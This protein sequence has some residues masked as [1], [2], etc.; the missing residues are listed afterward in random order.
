M[1]FCYNIDM[2]KEKLET[3]LHN[4]E[5]QNSPA[6]PPTRRSYA[7]VFVGGILAVLVIMSLLFLLSAQEKADNIPAHIGENVL[8][9]LRVDKNFSPYANK[10]YVEVSDGF[11]RND[12]RV[13]VGAVLPVISRQNFRALVLENYVTIGTAP[14]ALS[15]NISTNADD[16][17]LLRYLLSQDDMTKAFMARADVA[18]LLQDPVALARVASD[19]KA[20][21]KFFGQKAAQQVLASEQLIDV[22]SKSRFMSYLLIS[23]AVKYYRDNPE[24]AAQLVNASPTLSA[25]KQQPAIRKAVTEN[26]YLKDIAPTLLK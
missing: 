9:G 5:E 16:P 14:W 4:K 3:L 6:T 10:R 2:E 12:K 25:L 7:A 11:E 8:K 18:P 26:H 24:T 15:I 19:E 21:K 17:D 13:D 23:P 1:I 20:L 22:F